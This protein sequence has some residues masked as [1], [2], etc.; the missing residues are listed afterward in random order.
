MTDSSKKVG[1]IEEEC[2]KSFLDL[3]SSD[4]TFDEASLDGNYYVSVKD[5][6]RLKHDRIE[7]DRGTSKSAM[8]IEKKKV[9]D[10]KNFK[11]LFFKSYVEL[12]F[13]TSRAR[14]I[15]ENPFPGYA[16]FYQ[17][18]IRSKYMHSFYKIYL[19]RKIHPFS[20]MVSIEKH[21]N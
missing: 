7:D 4:I 19:D 10:I 1:F 21:A 14:T 5:L 16:F 17:I 11:V 15:L 20:Q 8:R 6:K 9:G 2:F 12:P 18:S 3:L 13:P